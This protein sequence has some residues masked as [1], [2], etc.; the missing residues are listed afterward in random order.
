M[1]NS[2]VEEGWARLA[3]RKINRKRNLG[4]R[5]EEEKKIREKEKETPQTSEIATSQQTQHRSYRN[6]NKK[7]QGKRQ[8]KTNRSI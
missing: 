2:W 7:P 3:G 1:A 6:K 4:S 8:I 5:T